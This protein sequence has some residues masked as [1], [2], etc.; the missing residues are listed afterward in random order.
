MCY[1]SQTDKFWVA[2]HKVFLIDLHYLCGTYYARLKGTHIK[3]TSQC[4]WSSL[5]AY[6]KFIPYA[7][8][9]F[10]RSTVNFL[11]VPFFSLQAHS[12]LWMLSSHCEHWFKMAGYGIFIYENS[13]FITPLFLSTDSTAFRGPSLNILEFEIAGPRCI[14]LRG[15][16]NLHW[17]GNSARV[18]LGL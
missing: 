12:R 16:Y 6:I 10:E 18:F 8:V 13:I 15:L 17:N 4:Q 7:T 3:L 1:S 5:F 14:A 9:I 11:P 2:L